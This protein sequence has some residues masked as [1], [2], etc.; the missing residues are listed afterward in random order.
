[1]VRADESAGFPLQSVRVRL[2]SPRRAVAGPTRFLPWGRPLLQSLA[3]T[4][5][6][7]VSVRCSPLALSPRSRVFPQ[8]PFPGRLDPGSSSL[9]VGSPPKSVRRA[10]RP[11]CRAAPRAVKPAAASRAR[12]SPCPGLAL[13]RSPFPTASQLPGAL[14]GRVASPAGSVFRFSRPLDG[15]RCPGSSRP[16]FMPLTLLGFALQSFPLPRNPCPFRGRCSPAVGRSPFAPTVIPCRL[17]TNDHPRSRRGWSPSRGASAFSGS[18]TTVVPRV[19][20]RHSPAP[21]P[22]SS[23]PRTAGP[24]RV[25]GENQ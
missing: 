23:G 11:V 18:P 10:N 2:V 21:H 12:A 7:P 19:P 5:V 1:V 17:V 8:P 9:G 20:V 3:G 13:L 22:R 14:Y 25:A 24:F 4:A 6:A 15:L 16:C